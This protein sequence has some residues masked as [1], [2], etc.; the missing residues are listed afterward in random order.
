MSVSAVGAL[1]YLLDCFVI[2]FLAM[3]EI[4]ARVSPADCVFSLQST[5]VIPAQAG[6]GTKQCEQREQNKRPPRRVRATPPP[7]GN[8]LRSCCGLSSPPVEEYPI[9]GGGLLS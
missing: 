4:L 9:G 2:S 5:L 3:T 8:L 1:F 7:E 6:I